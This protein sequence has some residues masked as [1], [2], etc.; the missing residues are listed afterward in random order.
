MHLIPAC[1]SFNSL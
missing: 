1:P